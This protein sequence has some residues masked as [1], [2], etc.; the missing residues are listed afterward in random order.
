VDYFI[1]TSPGAMIVRGAIAIILGIV[2]LL[3]PG[4]TFLALTIAFGVFALLDGISALI[5]L[6][7]R[8][9]RL[10]RGWLA[11]EAVAGILIGIITMIW[12][13]IAALNLVLLIAAWALVTGALKIA[14]AIRLRKRIRREW[15]LVLS[16][17]VSIIFGALL[18]WRPLL[19]IVGLVWALGIFG[20][21]YGALLVSLAIRMRR[22]DDL[23]EEVMPGAA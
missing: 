7:D 8:H 11:L 3:L 19:G 21:V 17:L 23:I 16:G 1:F 20:L 14:A 15:L 22:W 9:A 13:G 12:P 10:G 4:P 18:V 6:L 2:A 5:T